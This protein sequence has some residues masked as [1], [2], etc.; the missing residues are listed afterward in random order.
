MAG[1]GL[2]AGA[3][4]LASPASAN[5]NSVDVIVGNPGECGTTEITT[6]WA[7]ADHT[8]A[9]TVLVVQ[10]GGEQQ[11]AAVGES[12]SVGPFDSAEATIRWRIWGGG[13]R[14]HDDPP[15]T[16]LAALVAHLEGGGGE[17]DADPPGVAWHEVVVKGCE[18]DPDPTKP[19]AGGGDDLDCSDFA[20]QED[21]QAE[22]DKDPSDPHDLDRDGD[23]IACEA[24]PS[25]GQGGGGDDNG[26]LPV[27]G[28]SAPQL[29]GG[30]GALGLV[31]GGLYLLARR[32]RVSFTA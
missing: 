22:L 28:A 11:T 32:R 21:A 2:L 6:A 4:A 25:G 16:D 18:P 7:E 14:A 3:L 9:T 26:G 24:L 30:A 20:T 5:H 19:P 27:T 15:L 17:L 8:V 13:E 31:G 29:L 12:L 1:M 23:G 10:A